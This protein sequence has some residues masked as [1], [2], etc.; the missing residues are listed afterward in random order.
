MPKLVEVRI[1]TFLK[2]YSNHYTIHKNPQQYIS[3]LTQMLKVRNHSNTYV[4]FI[5]KLML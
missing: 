4:S 3:V 5:Q 1:Q 2:T